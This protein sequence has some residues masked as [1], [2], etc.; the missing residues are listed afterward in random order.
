[1]QRHDASLHAESK[2]KKQKCRIPPA[3]RE[4][5]SQRAKALEVVIARGLEQQ[6]KAENEAAGANVRH[7]KIEHTGIARFGLLMFEANETIGSQSHEFPGD[8]EKEC[9]GSGKH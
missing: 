5:V 9:I 4:L 8:K 2:K 3:G 7:D 6:Q 1:M